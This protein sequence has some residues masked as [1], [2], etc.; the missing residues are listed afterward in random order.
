[1]KGLW[2]HHLISKYCDGYFITYKIALQLGE[3]KHSWF[4]NK[5]QKLLK[6]YP[7]MVFVT[8]SRKID[9]VDC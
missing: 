3:K 9:Q 6:F 5:M 7:F 1:M 2:L 4:I 8:E